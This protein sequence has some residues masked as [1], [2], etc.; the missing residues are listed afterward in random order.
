MR[1]LMRMVNTVFTLA[2]LAQPGCAVGEPSERFQPV[3]VRDA[4]SRPAAIGTTGVAYVTL[5]NTDTA[6]VHL[7]RVVSTVAARA[8]LHE[9][10]EHEGM[11]HMEARPDVLVAYGATVAMRP[12][13]LHVML[14]D[15]KRA[16]AAGDTVPLSLQ[17]SD[18]RAVRALAIVRAN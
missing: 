3:K 4:W 17:F 16:L 8:E 15:L 1:S 9:S 10:M 5:E 2:L 11:T 18:R 13:A 6:D 12:G 14:V 7:T